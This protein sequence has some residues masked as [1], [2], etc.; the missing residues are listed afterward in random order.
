MTDE[1]T[2][3]GGTGTGGTSA[4]TGTSG[5]TAFSPG[6]TAATGGT[7]GSGST[8]GGSGGSSEDR[9]RTEAGRAADE[10]R[11]RGHAIAD[12]ARSEASRLAETARHKAEETA[13]GYKKQ[14][15]GEVDRMANALRDAGSNLR[16]GSPQE[17]AISSM[18]DNLADAADA[19]SNKDLG[20]LIGDAATFAR[21][22]PTAFLGSAAL[23][24][25]AAARFAKAS[26]RDPYEGSSYGG[27]S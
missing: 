15:A 2:N 11:T 23:L 14:A 27:S 12:E 16:Q 8:G 10:A 3:P 9:A 21:R 20:A 17:R 6:G 13:D 25:F 7:T 18:A 1:S 22:H 5:S 19:F 4:G 26:A 24:G